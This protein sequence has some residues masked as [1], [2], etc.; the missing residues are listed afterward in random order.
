MGKKKKCVKWIA[1]D[2]QQ[3]SFC[4]KASNTLW[5]SF[6]VGEH[7]HEQQVVEELIQTTFYTVAEVNQILA[8]FA[9]DASLPSSLRTS[10]QVLEPVSNWKP[11][12]KADHAWLKKTVLNCERSKNLPKLNIRLAKVEDHDD[13]IPIFN[14]QSQLPAEVRGKFFLANLIENQDQNNKTLVGEVRVIGLVCNFLF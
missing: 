6:L 4:Q 10:F 3:S 1:V 8:L 5:L 14:R 13:L 2:P 7:M 11:V 9:L 12:K